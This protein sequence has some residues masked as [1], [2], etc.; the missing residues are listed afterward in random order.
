[1]THE[2]LLEETLVFRVSKLF[3]EVTG[4]TRFDI[5]LGSGLLLLRGGGGRGGGGGGVGNEDRGGRMPGG[6]L[7]VPEALDNLCLAELVHHSKGI[8]NSAEVMREGVDDG[9]AGKVIIEVVQAEGIRGEGLDDPD[10]LINPVNN[11]IQRLRGVLPDRKE[12]LVGLEPGSRD[13]LDEGLFEGVPDFDWILS[14]IPGIDP[15][16]RGHAGDEDASCLVGLVHP[17]HILLPILLPLLKLLRSD[18]TGLGARL[19]RTG[20]CARDNHPELRH[21]EEIL[22]LINP[23][24]IVG[25]IQLG[26]FV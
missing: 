6:R 21:H 22:H 20:L 18:I 16:L 4:G 26:N 19:R 5:G 13:G 3:A 11:T 10:L 9:H 24:A 14:I 15:D 12:V 23:E 2:T 8:D 7:Q 1:L 25:S 17:L